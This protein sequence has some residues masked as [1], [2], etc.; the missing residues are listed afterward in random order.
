MAKLSQ[1]VIAAAVKV[2]GD[3]TIAIVEH[4]NAEQYTKIGFMEQFQSRFE[5]VLAS[6][7]VVISKHQSP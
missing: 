6:V 5:D 7:E 3:W 2:A 1:E 4:R